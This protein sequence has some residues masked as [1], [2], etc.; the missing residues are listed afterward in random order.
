[1]CRKPSYI[2]KKENCVL[3]VKIWLITVDPRLTPSKEVYGA[4][5]TVGSQERKC[6][7]A[8]MNFTLRQKA[9]IT[10]TI[11]GDAFVQKTGS[12]NARLRLEHG[13]KQKD[14]LLWKGQQFPKLFIGTPERIE[15][16]HPDTKKTYTYW[17]WQSNATPALGIWRARFYP[18]GK[19]RIPE[20]LEEMLKQTIALAVWYMDDGYY[21]PE[22]KHSFLYLGRVTKHEANIAAESIQH[23][24]DLAVRIYD[25]KNKGFAL[26]FSVAETKKLHALIASDITASMQYKLSLTP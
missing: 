20:N 3:G 9:I 13:E 15:R 25:K 8:C 7:L 19:K 16:V 14:Y 26:F 18:H 21:S 22:Q 6:I 17:R 2:F 10:G 11:L 24:F 4:R 1:M 5:N 23:N 12:K